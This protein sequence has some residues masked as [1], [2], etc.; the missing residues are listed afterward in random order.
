M[1]LGIAHGDL[2]PMNVLVKDNL[3]LC[4]TDMGTSVHCTEDGSVNHPH[5]L[6]FGTARYASPEVLEG[7]MDPSSFEEYKM[8]DIYSLS[9]IVYEIFISTRGKLKLTKM[10]LNLHRVVLITFFFL[11]R[12]WISRTSPSC[13]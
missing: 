13:I 4:L 8:S 12:V 1:L 2:K 9:L 10:I 5:K 11:R 3:S 6:P 7:K